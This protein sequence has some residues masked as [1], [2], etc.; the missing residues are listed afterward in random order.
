MLFSVARETVGRQ[1]PSGG[2]G[3][4]EKRAFWARC[5]KKKKQGDK[6]CRLQ[7]RKSG[8]S[9]RNPGENNYL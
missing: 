8:G 3:R 1:G 7:E 4:Q 9:D 2:P 5:P 6:S